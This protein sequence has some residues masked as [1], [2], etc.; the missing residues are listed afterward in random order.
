MDRRTS[1]RLFWYSDR[2]ELLYMSCYA[3]RH[4]P[5]GTI[6]LNFYGNVIVDR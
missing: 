1:I 3:T 4:P 5:V 6:S 2:S